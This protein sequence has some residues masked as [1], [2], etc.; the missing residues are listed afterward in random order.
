MKEKPGTQKPKEASNPKAKE[1][2]PPCKNCTTPAAPQQGSK[3]PVK[4]LKR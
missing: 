4:D 2:K 1:Q 3:A